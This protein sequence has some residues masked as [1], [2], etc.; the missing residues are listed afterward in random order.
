MATRRKYT[1]KRKKQTLISPKS[2]KWILGLFLLLCTIVF[3]YQ[4]KD[5]F[6][7]YLGF[8][9]KNTELKMVILT[10]LP[11]KYQQEIVK[12]MSESDQEEFQFQ[13]ASQSS[14][15]NIIM[16]FAKDKNNI[17]YKNLASYGLCFLCN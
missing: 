7:Y 12:N 17:Y 3:V 15:K 8:K 14:E 16:N 9:T 11:I 2:F 4:K 13:L 5:M 10:V 1:S 6:L